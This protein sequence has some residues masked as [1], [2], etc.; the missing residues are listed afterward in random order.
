MSGDSGG[1]MRT[2]HLAA[3]GLA[4]VLLTACGGSDG[5]GE[6]AKTGPQV[7]ADAANALEKAGA[8]HLTGGGTINGQKTD[9]DLHLQGN[10]AKG[11]IAEGGTRLQVVIT[12]WKFYVQAPS[13]YWSQSGVPATAAAALDGKW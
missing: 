12:G 10:D 1:R 5:N 13:S 2:R 6:S 8:V 4:A 9:V 7:A 3:I 11:T